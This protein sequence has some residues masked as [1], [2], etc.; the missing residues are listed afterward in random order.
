MKHDLNPIPSDL[1]EMDLSE[2][3]IRQAEESFADPRPS[4]PAPQV[5]RELRAIHKDAEQESAH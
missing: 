2:W 3:L 5:F 4:V 1:D